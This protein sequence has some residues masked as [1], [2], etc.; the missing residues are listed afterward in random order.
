MNRQRNDRRKP[1]VKNYRSSS[2][3]HVN[4]TPELESLET[5]TLFAALGGGLGGALG[6]FGT[7]VQPAD[8]VPPDV[9]PTTTPKPTA[10]TSTPSPLP[11]PNPTPTATPS[12][13]PTPT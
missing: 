6:R 11:S 1:A 10:P 13:T 2:T 5:R 12:P 7:P 8:V 3:G 9:T 4:V